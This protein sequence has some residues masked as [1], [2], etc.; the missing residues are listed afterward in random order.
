MNRLLRRDSLNVLMKHVGG[1]S[2]QQRIKQSPLL[3]L[4]RVR[5]VKLVRTGHWLLPAHFGD[6]AAE[7]DAVRNHV[8][9]LDLCQRNFLRFTGQ[10]RTRFLNN[11]I[12]NDLNGLTGGH[13]LH[14]A[15]TDRSSHV[16]ADARIFCA[17]DFL[18]VDIPES[19]K[20]IILQH[21]RRRLETRKVKIED[22]SSDY[23]MLSIQGPQAERLLA[24]AASTNDLYLMD[25][26]HLQVEI[27]GSNVF[28]IVVTHGAERGYDLVIPVTELPAVIS[29][30][31]QVGKRWS[32]L[33]VGIEAQEILRIE[34]GIPVYGADINEET[35]LSETGQ[36]RWISFNR[37]LAGLI[38]NGNHPVQSGAKVYDDKRE[39]GSVTSSCF[40][41][42]R[43]SVIALAY[44]RR[45]YLI[46]GTQ[47]TIRVDGK[48]LVAVVSLLPIG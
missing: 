29:H 5:G 26:A 28:L 40:S 3:D 22:V 25:L 24:E 38:L 36:A 19:R 16:L 6:P 23:A 27:A 34:A 10:D 2:R 35:L 33:W 20:E 14:A 37:R 9:I 44:I 7:Y 21:L 30:I 13:G 18:L 17:K 31:E 45:D 39:I 4:Y 43:D 11:S 8:G 12:S 32:L 46:P 41:P 15:F 42:Q 1:P 47:V 48:H